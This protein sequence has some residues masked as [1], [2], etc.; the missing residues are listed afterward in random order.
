MGPR[1]R[2]KCGPLLPF[3][4]GLGLGSLLVSQIIRPFF[5]G[6]PEL[7]VT[8]V[9]I[10]TSRPTSQPANFSQSHTYA[11]LLRVR[12]QSLLQHSP[13][14]PTSSIASSF[15]LSIQQVSC[16]IALF[17]GKRVVME[18]RQTG[19]HSA[20]CRL[21]RKGRKEERKKEREKR[22]ETT[23][24]V[25]GGITNFE[26]DSNCPQHHHHHHQQLYIHTANQRLVAK[27]SLESNGSIVTLF[28]TP[29]MYCVVSALGKKIQTDR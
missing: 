27:I 5:I 11:K 7:T 10:A 3:S 20:C 24:I 15:L 28:A 1:H 19:A 29:L 17:S 8:A 23:S 18:G 2:A 6:R 25:A 16:R 13:R 21:V 22:K 14:I 26:I 4:A 9:R 12:H